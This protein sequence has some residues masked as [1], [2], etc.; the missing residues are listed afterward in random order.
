MTQDSKVP[1]DFPAFAQAAQA[2]PTTEQEP[3]LKVH[4]GEFCCKSTDD[5]Q[6][7]AMWCPVTPDLYGFPDGTVFYTAAPK[8]T[9]LTVE[10]YT[11][12]AHRIASRYV[13]RSAPSNV[14]YTFLPHTLDDFVRAIEA[15][16]TKGEKP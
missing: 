14:A 1:C 3:V 7:F 9:P 4:K 15:A 11:A 10:D 16:I 13:H 12:L 8:P 5:D 2:Q 6:S